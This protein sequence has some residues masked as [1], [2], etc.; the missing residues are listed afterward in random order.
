MPRIKEVTLYNYDEL[1]DEAKEKA[2]DWYRES[3]S[4]DDWW[5]STYED[6]ERIGLKITAFDIDR[7]SYVQAKF[8][9]GAYE[10]AKLILAKHGKECE[11]YKTA[12]SYIQAVDKVYDLEKQD[13][14]Y[15]S[16][17]DI[18]EIDKE[19]LK[20]IQKEYRI[21]L[22]KEYEYINSD[23]YVEENI[24]ANEYEFT[25]EGGRA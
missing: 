12:Q 16:D 14:D 11:T 25:E 15:N 22:Q 24:Q 2:R 20:T 19:F 17:D 4:N 1:S 13:E 6:A 9:K 21:I 3:S 5:G 23:E 8:I 18:Y 7:G 10:C